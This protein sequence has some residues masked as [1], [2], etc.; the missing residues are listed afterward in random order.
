LFV[1]VALV[2]GAASPG[3]GQATRTWVSG[4]GDD[5]NPCSRTAPCKTFAGAISKTAAGGEIDALDPAGYGAVTITKAIT[6]DGGGTFA[7]ILASATNGVIVNAGATDKVVL[8]NLSINGTGTTL[9]INGIRFLAGNRLHVENCVISNFSNFGIDSTEGKS[10][11]VKDTTMR[12]ITGGGLSI[13]P[14]TSAVTAM[15]D[16]SRFEGNG[17]GVHIKGNVLATV[18]DSEAS[19]NTGPGFWAEGSPAEMNIDPSTS[20][21]NAVGVRATDSALVRIARMTVVHNATGLLTETS[22]QISSFDGD[23]ISGN[24]AAAGQAAACQLDTA[25]SLVSCPATG[26]TGSG[27]PTVNVSVSGKFGPCRRCKTHK[28]VTTCSSCPIT[29]Q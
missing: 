10:L 14:T 11:F 6:I 29:L 17:F 20:A 7:S 1:V 16:R 8:R 4:V 19:G 12:D 23:M 18:R 21:N 2:L 13:V 22:G 9:G 27:P 28:S 24:P 3:W 25:S 26:S 15:I 5:V